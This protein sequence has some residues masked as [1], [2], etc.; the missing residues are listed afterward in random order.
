MNKQIALLLINSVILTLFGVITIPAQ[1]KTIL[2]LADEYSIALKKYQQQKSQTSVESVLHKGK[3]VNNKIE[4]IENLSEADYTILEKKMKGFVIN[5]YEVLF[6]EPDL[7]F[8]TQLLKTHGTKADS[9]FVNLMRQIK[10]DNVFAKYIEMQTDVTGCTIYGNSVLTTLYGKVLQF[11]KTYPKAYTTDVNE[12][13]DKILE[14]FLEGTCACGSRN[15]VLKEFQLF[16]K[17]FQNDK[18]TPRIKK[19]LTK[20]T[21]DKDFR[22]NCQS[23]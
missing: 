12:E 3:A 8:Y 11:K 9:A 16:I 5:R 15:S 2:Q 19:R 17:T 7:K 14:E 4:D 1:N 23:G 22:F 20:L 21:K 13:T 10:P 18:N 6:I